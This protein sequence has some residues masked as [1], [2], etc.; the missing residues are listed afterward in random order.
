MDDSAQF[1]RFGREFWKRFDFFRAIE[2]KHVMEGP[3]QYSSEAFA[4]LRDAELCYAAKAYFAC[5]VICHSIIEIHLRKIEMLKGKASQLFRQAGIEQEMEWL[6]ALRNDIAHGNSNPEVTYG[7]DDDV[8][9]IW[10]KHCVKAFE[11]MHELPVRL[12]RAS[13]S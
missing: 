10:E 6:T 13:N 9:A 4:L 12:Y 7:V 11:V 5:I 8:E 3:F 2:V 1:E